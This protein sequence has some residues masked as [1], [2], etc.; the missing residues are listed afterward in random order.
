MTVIIVDSI[1][2]ITPQALINRLIDLGYEAESGTVKEGHFTIV[3]I[4][5]LTT[6]H[7]NAIQTA[8]EKTSEVSFN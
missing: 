8:I 2:N 7:Q 1:F 6:P 4:P 5:D 3:T